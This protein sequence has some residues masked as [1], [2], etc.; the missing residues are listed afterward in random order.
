MTR[1]HTLSQAV[2]GHHSVARSVAIVLGGSILLAISAQISVPMFPVPMT[3][4]TLMISLL[5]LT[6]GSRLAAATVVTYLAQGAMG[7]PVLA[8]GMGGLAPFMG[9]TAGFLAGFVL[10]A[11]LTGVL[12]ERGLGR[13]ALRLS[14]AAL[15]P[16]MLIYVP[17]VAWLTAATPLD[18]G[19]AVQAGML[20]FVLGDVVKSV[21]AGVVVAGGWAALRARR[22]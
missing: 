2:A 15:V 11:W 13:G 16:A 1:D 18:L 3:M 7:F 22:G 10:Q 6:L 21:L 4:Q 20:P 8:N 19:G 12:A 9:P 14:L 5:G 17:G